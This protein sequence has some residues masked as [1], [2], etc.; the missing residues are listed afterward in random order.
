MKIEHERKL[1]DAANLLHEA[2]LRLPNDYSITLTVYCCESSIEVTDP[3]G[4]P[5]ETGDHEYNYSAW[6]AAIDAAI[7]HDAQKGGE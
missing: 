2:A 6:S 3:D 5:V 4:N 7:E 1:I